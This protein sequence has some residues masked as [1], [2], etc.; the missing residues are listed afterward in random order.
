MRANSSASASAR[1]DGSGSGEVFPSK[2]MICAG[3]SPVRR[4]ISSVEGAS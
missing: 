2:R 3:A 4:A 1:V